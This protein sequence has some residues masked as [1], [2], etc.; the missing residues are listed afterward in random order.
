[1]HREDKVIIRLNGQV[2]EEFKKI[3]DE[4]GLTVSAMGAYVLGQFVR[5]QKRIV[6][7]IG[8][9]FMEGLAKKVAEEIKTPG[10]GGTVPG[11]DPSE[12]SEA[13]DP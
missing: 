9:A 8:E 11:G 6:D 1:M 12:R 4:H 2:K 3:A 5:T 10:D 7:P 13:K